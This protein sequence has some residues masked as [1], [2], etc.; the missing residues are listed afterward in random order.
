MTPFHKRINQATQRMAEDML[1]RNMAVRMHCQQMMH[2]VSNTPRPSWRD[3]FYG[4]A[5]HDWF[6]SCWRTTGRTT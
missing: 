1:I 5:H 2:P 4:P 3:L 6:E